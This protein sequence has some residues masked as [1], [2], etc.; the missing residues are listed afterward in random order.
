MLV[1]SLYKRSAFGKNNI[2]SGI[3]FKITKYTNNTIFL[4]VVHFRQPP[5]FWKAVEDRNIV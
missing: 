4:H 5:E 3:V 1:T 2:I